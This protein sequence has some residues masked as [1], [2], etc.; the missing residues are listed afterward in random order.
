M[1]FVLY[2]TQPQIA[3]TID[4]IPAECTIDTGAR[5]TITFMSPFM[6]AHPQI[7]P[8]KLTAVGVNG[9]GIGGPAMGR[10]GR[11]QRSASATFS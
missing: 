1:P 11:V 6:A 5:D 7:V 10:L 9:F 2:G 8:A 3:C 4:A